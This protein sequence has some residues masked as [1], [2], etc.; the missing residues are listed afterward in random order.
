MPNGIE[1]PSRVEGNPPKLRVKISLSNV[2]WFFK[3]QSRYI[4]VNII[5]TQ[6]LSLSCEVVWPWASRMA[7][8][9][10]PRKWKILLSRSFLDC[11]SLTS[12]VLQP[13]KISKMSNNIGLNLRWMTRI[14]EADPTA[15]AELSNAVSVKDQ[16]YTVRDN[17]SFQAEKFKVGLMTL[18]C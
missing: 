17:P 18:I 10:W 9:S 8:A 4:T 16:K 5:L 2:T 11:Q 14:R 7:F 1:L 15:L 12:V 13:H 3:V 6:Q